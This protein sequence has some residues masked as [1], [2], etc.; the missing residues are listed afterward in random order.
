M[1]RKAPATQ[2]TA[3]E[4]VEV[5]AFVPSILYT[6]STGSALVADL[7]VLAVR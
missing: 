6:Y 7:A 3:R 4:V 1:G 2:A 5:V